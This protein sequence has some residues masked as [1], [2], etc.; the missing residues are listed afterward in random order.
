MGC[1]DFLLAN[2]VGQGKKMKN[3]T[4]I[5]LSSLIFLLMSAA[6]VAN[7]DGGHME[8]R[9]AWMTKAGR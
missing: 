9:G 6:I 1:P 7:V 3:S 8:M 2:P 4:S 5:F